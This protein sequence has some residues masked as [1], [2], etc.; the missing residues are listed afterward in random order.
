MSGYKF[1]LH[2]IVFLI[3][4]RLRRAGIMKKPI[5]HCVKKP[6]ASSRGNECQ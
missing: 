2:S 1:L 4:R 3:F 6:F 5:L